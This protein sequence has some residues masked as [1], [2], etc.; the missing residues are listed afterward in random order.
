MK[1]DLNSQGRCV[2]AV[3]LV[4][5]CQATFAADYAGAETRKGNT[6]GEACEKAKTSAALSAGTAGVSS[7]TIN[8]GSC[9]CDK[10]DASRFLNWECTV[11]W[12]ANKKHRY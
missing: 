4:A 9:D 10:V 12:E 1:L 3:M 6:K 5:S 11:S 2:M 8:L 7:N